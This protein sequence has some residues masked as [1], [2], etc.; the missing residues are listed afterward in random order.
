V[1]FRAF[2]VLLKIVY[3]EPCMKSLQK[4]AASCLIAGAMVSSAFAA[5]E[6]Y[7]VDTQGQ[8]AFIQFKIPHLGY[9]MLLGEF[10]KFDGS[11][12]VD[13][14]NLADSKVDITIKT[15]SLDSNH[16]QRD[17]HIR[18]GD[19]LNVSKFPEATFKSTKVEVTG[20]KTAKV[21]GDL[22]LHGVTKPITLDMTQIGAGDDPWGGY[23]MGFEGT[24]TFALADFGIDYDLG[25]ASK[26]VEIYVSIEGIKQ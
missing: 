23:R 19:M 26:E 6:T 16:A 2:F 13:T 10:T 20:D 18:G 21:H 12:T 3:E 9:S 11:F 24:T 22:T 5:P 15:E 17:K 25:P 8:H 1:N 4:I 7:K 14:E